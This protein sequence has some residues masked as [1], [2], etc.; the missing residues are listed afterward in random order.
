M[1]C[2]IDIHDDVVI[3]WCDNRDGSEPLRPMGRPAVTAD[4]AIEKIKA[5]FPDATYRITDK[6]TPP[7]TT[8]ITSSK[9][10]TS[11]RLQAI[12]NRKD[13]DAIGDA[14]DARYDFD[15]DS[16][17]SELYATGL[18]QGVELGLKLV[19]QPGASIWVVAFAGYVDDD[20]S[21]WFVGT[22]DEVAA[23]LEALA[24]AEDADADD[25]S[26][27]DAETDTT[28]VNRRS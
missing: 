7:K 8:A 24:D 14:A 26:D 12:A 11:E 4:Q 19:A 17:D 16:V 25:G 2:F 13:T 22:E 28:W 3:F 1:E 10:Q 18:E 6:R 15:V 23:R 20:S 27:D 21:A 5:L 9:V